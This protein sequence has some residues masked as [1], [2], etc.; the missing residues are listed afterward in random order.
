MYITS[1]ENMTGKINYVILIIRS[2]IT[3]YSPKTK[4]KK[5][6]ITIKQNWKRGKPRLITVRYVV[7]WIMFQSCLFVLLYTFQDNPVLKT[8]EI[9]APPNPR[10]SHPLISVRERV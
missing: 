2:I 3:F 6:R 5:K 9:T 10:D 7:V 4:Q 8:P 1:I